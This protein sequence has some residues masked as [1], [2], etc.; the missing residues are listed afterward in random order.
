MSGRIEVVCIGTL[1][2]GYLREGC[3]RYRKMASAYAD[4]RITE[5]PE[6][7]LRQD[8]PEGIRRVVEQEGE[9]L[10]RLLKGRQ[11]RTIALC[12]DAPQ[13]DSMEL[14][15]KFQESFKAGQSVLLVIGGSHGLSETLLQKMDERLSLSRLT[16]PHQL[17]RL[18]LLEQTYRALSILAGGKYHK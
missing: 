15:D 10:E 1:S 13:C 5:L 18:I 14:A 4:I 9:S 7:R 17:C 6:A 12:V 2:Q 3:E 11:G 8:N 16:F